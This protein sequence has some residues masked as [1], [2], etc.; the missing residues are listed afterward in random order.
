M[1]KALKALAIVGGS[2]VVALVGY[3]GAVGGWGL[4]PDV[5]LWL[6]GTTVGLLGGTAVAGVM[7]WLPQ[8]D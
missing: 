4:P 1:A 6:V 3:A 2:V 8:E 7:G 5:S